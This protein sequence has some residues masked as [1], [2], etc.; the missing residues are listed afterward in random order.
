MPRWLRVGTDSGCRCSASW[1][2]VLRFLQFALLGQGQA[3]LVVRF[4]QVR[5]QLQSV[6]EIGCRP[7]QMALLAQGRAQVQIRLR[8]VRL[9]TERLMQSGHRFLKSALLTQGDS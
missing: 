5:T 6:A 7:F 8:T 3:E 2:D 4:G 1:Y 9:D